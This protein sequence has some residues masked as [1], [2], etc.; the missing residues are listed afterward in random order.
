MRVL[1]LM[2]FPLFN[3]QLCLK[4]VPG[5]LYEFAFRGKPYASRIPSFSEL[6]PKIKANTYR[7]LTP[8]VSVYARSTQPV[9]T[10][11]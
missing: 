6:V 1:E 11:R 5:L 10:R 4:L 9:V 3:P 2:V 7:F 8:S